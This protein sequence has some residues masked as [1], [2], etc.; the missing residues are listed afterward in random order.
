MDIGVNLTD[1]L[2]SHKTRDQFAKLI[3]GHTAGFFTSKLVEN[4]YDKVIV[5]RRNKTS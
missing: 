5:I 2:K 1:N 3:L 4:L